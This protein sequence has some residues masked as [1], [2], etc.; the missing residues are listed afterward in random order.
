MEH[1]GVLIPGLN[2]IGGAEQQVILLAK[3]LVRR[4]WRVTVIVLS[5]DGGTAAS[6]LMA[7]GVGFLRLNMRKG[8]ADP[9]G[10]LQLREW[11]KRE[12]PEILHAHLPHAAWM[13]RLFRLRTPCR[14]VI[15]TLHSS[16]TGTAIRRA[17]YRMSDGL[18]DRV[19]AVSEAVADTH[20][21]AKMVCPEKLRVLGNGIDLYRW[22][23]D[24]RMR[25]EFRRELG[26]SGEFLWVAVG[27]LEAVKDYPTLLSAF[28][29]LHG[30]SHLAIAGAGPLKEELLRQARDLNISTRVRFL[31]FEPDVLRWL[32]AA[33]G[34]VLASRWEGLPMVLLEAAACEL[35]IAATAAPGTRELIVDGQSGF[36]SP[37]GDAGALAASMKRIQHLDPSERAAMAMRA[38]IEI[39]GKFSLESALDR[40]ESLYREMLERNLYPRRHAL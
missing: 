2:R 13:A 27:R 39:A 38:R 35:P 18:T 36:L 14:V 21:S 24:P 26:L 5:G 28:A 4:G 40:W 30:G 11:V 15:D 31:D 8:L 34:F 3:G 37:V 10:W 12:K 1:V 25:Q 32:Q 9:R 22:C 19:T 23:P 17:G 6:S 33:D 29:Q 20:L 7:S 16:S